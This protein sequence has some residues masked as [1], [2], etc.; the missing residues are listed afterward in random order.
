MSA[1]RVMMVN[2]A[3]DHGLTSPAI[4]RR[5]T[6]TALASDR[7]GRGCGSSSLARPLTPGVL[8][9]GATGRQVGDSGV[10]CSVCSHRSVPEWCLA[11][12][13]E[14]DSPVNSSPNFNLVAGDVGEPPFSITGAIH[15]MVYGI[16]VGESNR[17]RVGW[18]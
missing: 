6:V 10:V 5:L 15:L 2:E 7:S 14:F 13:N 18:R 9:F 4:A 16:D 17:G 3:P 11:P 12:W 8:V 1:A